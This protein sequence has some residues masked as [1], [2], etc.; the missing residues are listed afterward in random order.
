[1]TPA[2]AIALDAVEKRYPNGTL[3]NSGVSFTVAAGEIHA[4]VGENGAGKSTVMKMLYGLEQP[5]AG[6]LRIHGREA[7]FRHPGEAIAAGVGLVAQ[8]LNLMPSLT[9]AENVVLGHEPRKP[10][11]RLDRAA[12]EARVLDLARQSGLDVDPAATVASLPVGVRQRVEILKVLHRGANILLL[13]EPTAV[14]TP[15]EA[16]AL[17]TT[18]RQ[19]AATGRTV[20]VITHKMDEVRTLAGGV[21]VLCQGRVTGS[22]RMADLDQG[23]LARLMVGRDLPPPPPRRPAGARPAPRVV[24]R[25]LGYVDGGGT[26]RLR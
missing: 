11:G 25:D 20:L 23:T 9:V 1:M 10:G 19:L 2:E 21:T 4:L 18:L 15:P 13:D 5:T 7:R 12:A 14:L 24:A 8:H 26:I 6:T 16:A 17:F 3:A 22:A